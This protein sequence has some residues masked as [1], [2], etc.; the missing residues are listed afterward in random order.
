MKRK[1]FVLIL[2]LLLIGQSTGVSAY[3]VKVNLKANMPWVNSDKVNR[4]QISTYGSVSSASLKNVAWVMEYR[5]NDGQ[6]H[7]QKDVKNWDRFS[8]GTSVPTL[9]GK[10]YSK[11]DQRLQL[12]PDGAG[13]SGKGGIATGYVNIV[14]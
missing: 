14:K 4:K 10:L 13:D 6:W 9:T 7:Y 5:G 2:G 1:C 12:N 8:P 11:S 3:A